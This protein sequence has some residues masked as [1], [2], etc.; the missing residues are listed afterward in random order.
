[1][2]TQGYPAGE[3]VWLIVRRKEDGSLQYYLS[4]APSDIDPEE[5]KR[6]MT[7]RWPIEQCFEDGKKYL[8]MDH[9]EHRTWNGWHRHMLYV[10]LA[11]L[12]LLRLRLKLKKKLRRLPSPRS[13]EY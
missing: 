13:S 9:Y 2:T 7:M 1:M 5:L 6:A 3:E 4:N 10:F 11:L 8:G 12:F